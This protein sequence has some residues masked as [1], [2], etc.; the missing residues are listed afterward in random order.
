MNILELYRQ[1]GYRPRRVSSACGGEWAGSCPFCGGDPASS[2][3]FHLWPSGKA[4]GRFW[5]RQ[6]KSKGD[7]IQYLRDVRKMT[8]KEACRMIGIK[9]E[10]RLGSRTERHRLARFSTSSPYNFEPK[11]YPPPDQLWQVP[12]KQFLISC[13]GNLWGGKAEV[14]RNWL[15]NERILTEETLRKH[16]IGYNPKDLFIPR[17]TWGLPPELDERGRPRKLWIPEGVVIPILRGAELYQLRIRRLNFQD[18][19]KYIFVA[20]GSAAPM[21]IHNRKKHTVVVESALDAILIDQEAGSLV[22]VLALGSVSMRPDTEAH[23]VLSSS[24]DILVALDTGDA[25]SAGAKEAWRWWRT[26]YEHAL[27]CPII[28]GKDPTEAALNGVNLWSWIEAAL[29]GGAVVMKK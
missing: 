10:G 6:C 19:K 27:R 14:A 24:R 25:T 4:G 26:H 9:I 13:M 29:A 5:C 8:F 22:N 28:G 11:G 12:A 18:G 16:C 17:E 1:D 2:D 21:T 7:A 20:G 15:L 23:R 3:R